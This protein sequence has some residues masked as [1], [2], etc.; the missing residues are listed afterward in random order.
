[1]RPPPAR[2]PCLPP[3][4]SAAPRSEL[5]DS[6]SPSSSHKVCKMSSLDLALPLPSSPPAAS[7]ASASPPP[8]SANALPPPPVGILD[9]CTVCVVL[10][11]SPSAAQSN[12]DLELLSAPPQPTLGRPGQVGGGSMEVELPASASAR[13][14][15]STSPVI[16]AGMLVADTLAFLKADPAIGGRMVG[17]GSTPAPLVGISFAQLS[18]SLMSMPSSLSGPDQVDPSSTCVSCAVLE[19]SSKCHGW[20]DWL[21]CFKGKAN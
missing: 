9:G 1:M 8:V 11:A 4:A 2:S 3:A 12:P 7:R 19:A 21:G 13:L 20:G 17:A 16:S 5:C 15:A 14:P 10:P 6:C 18:T